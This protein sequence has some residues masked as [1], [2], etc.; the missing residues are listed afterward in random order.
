MVKSERR[1]S[2]EEGAGLKTDE[3]A[4]DIFSSAGVTMSLHV[5]NTSNDVNNNI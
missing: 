2:T 1:R 4:Q 5:L 3:D